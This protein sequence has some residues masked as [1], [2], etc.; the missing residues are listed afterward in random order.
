MLV[1]NFFVNGRNS[2]FRWVAAPGD[3]I[4]D[5]ANGSRLFGLEYNADLNAPEVVEIR[6][7]RLPDGSL[8]VFPDAVIVTLCRA[9]NMMV[10]R[11]CINNIIMFFEL[12]YTSGASKQAEERAEALLK[13]WLTPRQLK[14][15][16]KHGWFI[17]RGSHSG[18]RYRI[19]KQHSW[20]VQSFAYHYCFLPEDANSL[21]DIM[22]TQK[23]ALETDEQKALAVANVSARSLD[24]VIIGAGR[25]A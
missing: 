13:Q 11:N 1:L 21:G 5:T 8:R 4:L 3:E 23:L 25:R 22:L 15:Y 7:E 24:R 6:V 10:Q 9:D 16:E 18:R 19:T 17:V 20:G 2:Y 12:G 14:Q